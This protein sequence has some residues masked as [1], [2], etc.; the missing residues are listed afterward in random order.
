M[1][2]VHYA[3]KIQELKVNGQIISSPLHL[4]RMPSERTGAIQLPKGEQH[5]GKL[6]RE[7]VSHVFWGQAELLYLDGVE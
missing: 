1:A 6:H 3:S 2:C 4:Q 7:T 5:L